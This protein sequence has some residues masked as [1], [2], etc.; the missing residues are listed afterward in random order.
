MEL[1]SVIKKKGRPKGKFIKDIKMDR[2]YGVGYKHLNNTFILCEENGI[3]T[4]TS[5]EPLTTKEAQQLNIVKWDIEEDADLFVKSIDQCKL[6][7][8]YLEVFY[9]GLLMELL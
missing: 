2:W 7:N 9:S 3:K 5:L 8:I 6:E 4:F 1:C